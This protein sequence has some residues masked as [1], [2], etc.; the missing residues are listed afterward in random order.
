[1]VTAREQAQQRVENKAKWLDAN[2]GSGGLEEFVRWVSQWVSQEYK[3]D[4]PK[5]YLEKE[6][7]DSP[8]YRSLSR[9]AILIYLDF[10]GKRFLKQVKRDKKRV[11]VIENNGDIK[12]PYTEAVD[13]GISKKKFV[14]AI[15]E[16][17]QKGLLD[18][19]HQ[20][21]GG[22]KPAKGTGDVT[23]YWIDDRWKKYGTDDFR[24]PR[25]PRKKDT[26]KGQGFELIWKD[27]ERGESMNRKAHAT[28]KR[29]NLSIE[30]DTRFGLTGI[31]ND[32]R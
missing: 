18:I 20:G 4:E 13:R 23:T 25:N 31:E 10:L 3:K 17:Q 12:Y 5:I 21:K 15:D 14:K 7:I 1:M 16:L 11:W 19:T 8:A 27:R 22:R 30:N 28:L 6:L 29:K 9:I 32:T 2:P 26:R 24:P